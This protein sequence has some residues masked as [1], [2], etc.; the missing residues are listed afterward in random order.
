MFAKVNE[1]VGLFLLPDM[2][3]RIISFNGEFRFARFSRITVAG[4]TG[5]NLPSLSIDQISRF[6]LMQD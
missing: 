4:V 5:L 2:L 1:I 3:S 6:Q